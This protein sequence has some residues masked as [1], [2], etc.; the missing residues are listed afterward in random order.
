MLT[1]RCGDPEQH[2]FAPTAAAAAETETAQKVSPQ[3]WASSRRALFCH[4]SPPRPSRQPRIGYKHRLRR[5][6]AT[7]LGFFSC[8]CVCVVTSP[9]ALWNWWRF[10]S[11]IRPKRGVLS[12]S[13]DKFKMRSSPQPRG[14][15]GFAVIFLLSLRLQRGCGAHA[16]TCPPPCACSGE[17]VDCSRLRRGQIPNTIPEWTVQL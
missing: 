2:K 15:A 5:S 13:R 12:L 9:L 11:K 14:F 7:D 3:E 17:L 4:L 10:I 1:L 6:E 8:V 16:G